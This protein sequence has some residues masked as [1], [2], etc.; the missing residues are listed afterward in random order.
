MDWYNGKALSGLCFSLARP[1]DC[2]LYA[3]SSLAVLLLGSSLVGVASPSLCRHRHLALL[4]L[5]LPLGQL[6]PVSCFCC[7]WNRFTVAMPTPA[8]S[9]IC[10]AEGS[11]WPSSAKG[12]SSLMTWMIRSRV[13]LRLV[14]PAACL[15]ACWLAALCSGVR[16]GLSQPVSYTHLTLPTTPYV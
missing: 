2:V 16:V 5:L 6:L 15:P 1:L 4:G 8:R 7:A 13:A 12:F 14:C 11:G 9:A 10:R 3:F